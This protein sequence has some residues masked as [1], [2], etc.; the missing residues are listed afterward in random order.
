LSYFKVIIATS[1]NYGKNKFGQFKFL[2]SVIFLEAVTGSN[3]NNSNML[4]DKTHGLK[5][6]DHAI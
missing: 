2:T 3:A 1:N 6:I 4:V 5:R